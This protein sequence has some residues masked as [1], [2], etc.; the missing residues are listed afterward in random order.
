MTKAE[1]LSR[2][3]VRPALQA[4]F[5]AAGQRGRPSVDITALSAN[6][7]TLH[8]IAAREISMK[9]SLRDIAKAAGVGKTTLYDAARQQGEVAEWL[10]KIRALKT[11]RAERRDA[12]R[13]V[14]ESHTEEQV[15]GTQTGK[16]V[17]PSGYEPDDIGRLARRFA[18][19]REKAVIAVRQCA[20]RQRTHRELAD[21]PLVVRDLQETV[22][23]LSSAL[24]ELRPLLDAW[25][26][27]REVAQE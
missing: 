9:L 27:R 2:S 21:L 18:P 14:G 20:G 4:P 15:G 23:L 3:T 22:T 26:R 1:Q 25:E 16:P 13:A 19:A 17:S 10:E 6:L 11:I 5:E 12:I 7:K 8:A 24:D